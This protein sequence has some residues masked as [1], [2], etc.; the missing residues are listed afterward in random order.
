M[1][2][3]VHRLS[4]RLFLREA[5]GGIAVAVLAPGVLGA[6]S[7]DGDV[8]A[9]PTTRD[10]ADTTETT[11]TSDVAETT[12][13]GSLRWERVVL[14]NVSAYV[15]ARGREIAIVDTGF[16]GSSDQIGVALDALG[17]SWSDVDHV[18][19][20]H[21]HG[22]HVGGL[23]EVLELAADA[24]AWAGAADVDA[25]DSPRPIMPLDDGD[26]VFGLEVIATP[27]HTPGHIS[28]LD[29]AASFLVAGDALNEDGGMVLGPNPAFTSDMDLANASVARLAERGFETVVFG[30]GAPIEGGASDAVVALAQTL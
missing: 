5:G 12:V 22:D 23:P 2:G 20:T 7:S 1:T 18:V 14:G 10:T 3:A 9:T 29:P 26:E 19:L 6:C 25:I 8:V 4:R 24:V 27:G 17:G 11:G 30:H 15:L 21:L 13:E 28:V 16:P